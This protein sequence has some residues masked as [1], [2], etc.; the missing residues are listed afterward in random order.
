MKRDNKFLNCTIE[1]QIDC[2]V[3][4]ECDR[5]CPKCAEIIKNWFFFFFFFFLCSTKT[6][7]SCLE[8]GP[9]IEESFENWYAG[10]D[11]C[12]VV[13]NRT[14]ER[15]K[16]YNG[17]KIGFFKDSLKVYHRFFPG[18]GKSRIQ[19]SLIGYLKKELKGL[20][21]FLYACS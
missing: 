14:F 17:P 3:Y 16:E 5:T 4:G 7:I 10:R 18:F 20:P 2:H 19:H 11:Q 8:I 15:K 21:D 9:P 13:H 1:L 12:E 6:S